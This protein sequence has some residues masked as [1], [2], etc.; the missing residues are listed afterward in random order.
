MHRRRMRVSGGGFAGRGE[1]VVVSPGPR[2]GGG[3]VGRPVAVAGYGMTTRKTPLARDD[4]LTA[5]ELN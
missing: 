2:D 4:G 5:S 1:G 3:V